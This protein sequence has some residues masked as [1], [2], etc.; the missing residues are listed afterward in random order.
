MPNVV[1]RQAKVRLEIDGIVFDFDAVGLSMETHQDVID[2]TT[3]DQNFRSYIPGP[4]RTT[5]QMEVI[6]AVTVGDSQTTP[7]EAGEI[8]ERKM[9]R[10][11]Y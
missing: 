9:R 1:G 11:D 7:Q 10:I 2:V 8:L 6:G 4:S 3:M 5:F